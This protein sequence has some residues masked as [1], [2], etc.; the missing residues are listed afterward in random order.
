MKRSVSKNRQYFAHRTV[1]HLAGRFSVVCRR[2][3]MPLI[4][5]GRP[6]IAHKFVRFAFWTIYLPKNNIWY[7]EKNN[8]EQ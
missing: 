5:G 6:A 2:L 8:F 7:L 3:A 1:K 4:S